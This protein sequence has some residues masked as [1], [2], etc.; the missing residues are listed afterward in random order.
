VG[1]SASGRQQ[2]DDPAVVQVFVDKGVVDTQPDLLRAID[3]YFDAH[4]NL[5]SLATPPAIVPGGESVKNDPDALEAVLRRIDEARLCRRSYVL[6]IGGGAVLDIVGFAAATA[7][8]GV[9]LVRLP[10]TTLS[11]AD[12]GVGVKNGVNRFGKKNFLGVFAPPWA[13]V[14]DTD[15]LATLS[16]RDWRAGFSEAAKVALVKD[17]LFF[18]QIAERAAAIR[19][20]NMGIALPIVRQSAELH[21]RHIVEGGDPFELT[22]ARPLD[23]GHWAAHKLEAMT[24]YRLRHGE[25]VAIGI[26]LD[27]TCSALCGYLAW[28]VAAEICDVLGALGLPAY[29]EALNDTERLLDGLE[30]FREHLGGR[31]TVPLLRGIG[32]SF[33]AHEIKAARVREAVERLVATCKVRQPQRAAS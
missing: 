8:R 25:A 10:S 16:D 19:E 23:F 20:R 31:L 21:A 29:D 33:D 11:Q 3:A 5:T 12:S 18:R 1:A 28:D 22:H 9:R 2:A 26:A 4:A 7:H 6:V 27:A 32:E 24:D 14:N 30:E 13:I 15:L 17:R